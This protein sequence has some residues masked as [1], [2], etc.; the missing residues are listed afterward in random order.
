[1]KSKPAILFWLLLFWLSHHLHSQNSVFASKELVTDLLY[2]ELVGIKEDLH[3]HPELAGQE[4][5]TSKIVENYLLD[6]GLEVKKGFG[7]NG[8]V[9][10]LNGHKEGKKIAWRA[11]MDAA[12]HVFDDNPNSK[13]QIAHICGHDVHTVI[14][15]GIANVLS[16]MKDSINGTVYFIFQPAEESFEGAKSMIGDGLFQE[17]RPDEI[18]GLH[19]F[20]TEIGTV[21]S[22][23]NELFAYQRIIRLTF[24][25][26]IDEENFEEFFKETMRRFVRNKTD[27][28]PWSLEYLTHTEHG[29]MNPNTVYEDYFIVEPHIYRLYDDKT[30]SFECTYY[31]TDF[32]RLNT[33][34]KRITNNVIDSKYGEFYIKTSFTAERPTVINDP[35]L[36]GESLNILK[37]LYGEDDVR[38]FYGQM[39]YSNEDFIYYQYEVPGVMFLLGA[40]NKKKG[41][42]AL[43]HTSEFEVDEEVIRVG[44]NY[45]SN[46]LTKKINTNKS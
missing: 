30:I 26:T 35:K 9:G 7:G 21:S 22:K 10:I 6:L 43:P 33:I 31:E 28:K 37:D 19:V 20:P 18:F 23:P 12:M 11:D 16:K 45:F 34:S 24:D 25:D 42:Y 1:M 3:S 27:G 4:K 44:V 2:N 38:P 32:A 5:R 40:S 13:T 36:T 39:P 17:I 15:L 14:G 41:I 8:I 46:F 29:L